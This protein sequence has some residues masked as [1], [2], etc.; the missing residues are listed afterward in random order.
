LSASQVGISRKPVVDSRPQGK[1]D[2]VGLKVLLIRQI[3]HLRSNWS[4]LPANRR[5]IVQMTYLEDALA[6]LIVKSDRLRGLSVD[7]IS[8]IKPMKL[9][10]HGAVWF[11]MA[12]LNV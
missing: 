1:N 2:H 10:Y 3:S 5:Q 12:I 11:I 8:L 4:A 6:S 7:Q 9:L